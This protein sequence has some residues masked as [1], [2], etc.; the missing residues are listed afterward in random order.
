MTVPNHNFKFGD[1]LT[2]FDGPTPSVAGNGGALSQYNNTLFPFN[3]VGDTFKLGTTNGG[4]QV[5]ENAAAIDLASFGAGG[6]LFRDHQPIYINAT[7][8]RFTKIGHGWSNGQKV[9]YSTFSNALA[10]LVKENFYYVVGADANSFQLSA[11]LGGAEIDIGFPDTNSIHYLTK[12]DIAFVGA[13]Y[14]KQISYDLWDTGDA[15]FGK[16]LNCVRSALCGKEVTIKAS[17]RVMDTTS[18]FLGE[19]HT[20]DLGK[21]NFPNHFYFRYS[22]GRI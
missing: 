6:G 19:R 12:S 21:E 9:R 13:D 15:F 22:N 17:G 16:R 4:G 7:N 5:T 2:A 18:G 1:V 11:T 8:N 14:P 20:L 10:G 3:I